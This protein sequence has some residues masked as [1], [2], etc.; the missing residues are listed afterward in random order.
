[1]LIVGA[2][3]KAQIDSEIAIGWQVEKFAREGKKLKPLGK[4]L[5]PAPT[6][7]RRRDQGARDV[8]RM[9]DRMIKKQEAHDGTR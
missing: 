1:M 5:E 9:F 2:R 3:K 6:H 8:K 7:E 4:Y